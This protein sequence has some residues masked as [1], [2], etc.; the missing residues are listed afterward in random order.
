MKSLPLYIV[1]LALFVGVVVIVNEYLALP[2]V[3]IDPQ[4]RCVRVLVVEGDQMTK[5]SCAYAQDKRY[6]TE[7][8]GR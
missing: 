3:Q 5:K 6:T 8:V 2:V 7:Y 4:G 1:T